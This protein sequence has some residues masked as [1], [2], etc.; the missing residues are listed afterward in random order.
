MDEQTVDNEA[1]LKDYP[2][3]K[4]TLVM[5]VKR[6]ERYIIPNGKLF[7]KKNDKLLLI[8]ESKEEEIIE[9]IENHNDEKIKLNWNFNFDLLNKKNK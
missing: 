3:P 7:L 4:G 1:F 5:I 2:L 9:N 6:D 8:S